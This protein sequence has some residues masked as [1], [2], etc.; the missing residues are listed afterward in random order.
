MRETGGRSPES[1]SDQ[2]KP[3]S[4]L[5]IAST[6]QGPLGVQQQLP[7]PSPDFDVDVDVKV[8][9]ASPYLV[10]VLAQGDS[11]A[12]VQIISRITDIREC[13]SS[14]LLYNIAS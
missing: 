5:P 9:D 1:D 11:F 6:S 4:T 14:A 2:Q 8:C 12:A 7:T 3:T 10:S 13:L